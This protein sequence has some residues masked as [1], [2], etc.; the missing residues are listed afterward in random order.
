[1]KMIL[2]G[3]EGLASEAATGATGSTEAQA[4]P[5]RRMSKRLRAGLL[6]MN[7][8]P[9]EVSIDDQ[10]AI[11]TARCYCWWSTE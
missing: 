2:R 11:L 6:V 4:V 8:N 5:S 3:F 1:M 7:A 10:K 9:L